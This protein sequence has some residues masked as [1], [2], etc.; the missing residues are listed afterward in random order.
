MRSICKTLHV[1]ALYDCYNEDNLQQNV[2]WQNILQFIFIQELKYQWINGIKLFLYS[3]ECFSRNY[4]LFLELE[5][6]S[7]RIV[8]TPEKDKGCVWPSNL[9]LYCNYNGLVSLNI[10]M[11]PKRKI[12]WGTCPWLSHLRFPRGV[13]CVPFGIL[14]SFINIMKNHSF[15]TNIMKY[16]FVTDIFWW[17]NSVPCSTWNLA[18]R[19]DKRRLIFWLHQLPL[20]NYKVNYTSVY[21]SS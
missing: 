16:S 3:E 17:D 8:I 20:F 6:Y 4:C 2:L 1:C 13:V 12:F 7:S 19:E 11:F 5:F 9:C 18:T 21:V 15:V 10:E 14:S